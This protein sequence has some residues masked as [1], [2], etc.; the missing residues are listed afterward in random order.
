M[1]IHIQDD[2]CWICRKKE[3]LTRHHSLPRHLNPK[4]NITIPVCKKCHEE[5]NKN[6]VKGLYAYAYKIAQTSA[7]AKN[8]ARRIMGLLE[9]FMKKEEK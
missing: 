4:K 2:E 8:A 7:E 1:E 3:S 5:I 6:D 9:E